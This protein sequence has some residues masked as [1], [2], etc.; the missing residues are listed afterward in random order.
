[1]CLAGPT[2]CGSALNTRARGPTA[3]SS[4]IMERVF[5]GSGR[6]SGEKEMLSIRITYATRVAQDCR[7]SEWTSSGSRAEKWLT[8]SVHSQQ[9]VITV[10]AAGLW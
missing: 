9:Y 3:R 10:S 5:K 4:T 6:A 7:A 8:L 2:T 1:M